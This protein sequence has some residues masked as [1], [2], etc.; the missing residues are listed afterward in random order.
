MVKIPNIRLTFI[1]AADQAR[2]EQ[3]FKAGV[4]DGQAVSGKIGCKDSGDYA[5][6]TGTTAKDI[7]LRSG[8]PSRTL[9]DIW[10][11]G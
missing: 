11:V 3:L 10:S 2:F 4:G 6:E 7:L 8:L 1:T 9:E 5:D